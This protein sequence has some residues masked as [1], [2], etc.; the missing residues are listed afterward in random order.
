MGIAKK[1]IIPGALAAAGF[2]GMSGG[3]LLS[4]LQASAATD[5]TTSSQTSTTDS[6]TTPPRD[7]SKAGHVGK[8]G[9]AE[10]LLTGDNATKA[11]AAALAAVPGGT[12]QRVE[13]DEDGG[14]YEAHMTKSD[15]TRVTVIMDADFKVTSTETGGPGK[16]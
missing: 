1:L 2:V 16:R 15:G 3:A 9:K 11:T 5:T 10:E 14:V 6:T 13:T 12:I 7:E 4:S 8:N